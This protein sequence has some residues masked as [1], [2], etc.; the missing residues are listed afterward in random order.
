MKHLILFV[1]AVLAMLI[2]A[3]TPAQEE[4][5][6][7]I[8]AYYS[9]ERHDWSGIATTRLDTLWVDVFGLKGS[10]VDLLGIVGG[11]AEVGL[12]GG[13]LLLVVPIHPRISIGLGPALTKQSQSL[14][15]FFQDFEGFELGI[16]VSL[17]Y[18]MKF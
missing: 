10:T 3:S 12:A 15:N 8:A 2:P 4:A 5:R 9:L 17:N 1:I 14:E 13:A 16:S 7:S 11:N 6:Y 18:S